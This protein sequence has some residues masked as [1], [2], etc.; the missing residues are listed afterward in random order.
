MLVGTAR[1]SILP[2]AQVM[3]TQ[4]DD[5][6][7]SARRRGALLAWQHVATLP[8]TLPVV[9]CGDFSTD[10]ESDVGR[11]FLGRSR[12]VSTSLLNSGRRLLVPCKKG[13][14]SCALIGETQFNA[15][16]GVYHGRLRK[17]CQDQGCA[18]FRSFTRMASCTIRHGDRFK[19]PQVAASVY[20]GALE[21]GS[22]FLSS[23]CVNPINSILITGA[24]REF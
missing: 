10:K 15:Y 9:V 23:I 6:S 12:W 24:T 21:V 18:S 5:K 2:F 1:K 13:K 19:A 16:A 7:S 17:A 8:P 11:F 22:E 4:L 14:C 3:N 20:V